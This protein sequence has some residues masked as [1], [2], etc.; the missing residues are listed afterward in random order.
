[1]MK[2]MILFLV[3]PLSLINKA[4]SAGCLL[5]HGFGLWKSYPS[6]PLNVDG[7]SSYPINFADCETRCNTTVKLKIK[8]NMH[9]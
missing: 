9:F 1:M 7:H 2:R 5:K 8:C 6:M 3:F 4:E